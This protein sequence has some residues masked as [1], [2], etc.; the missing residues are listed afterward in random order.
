MALLAPVLGGIADRG[1]A[2]KRALFLFTS[3]GI[4]ATMALFFAEEGNWPLAA[5]LYAIAVM[6]SL[7]A[8]VFYDSLL[9]DVSDSRTVD[10][11][12]GRGY[13][14]GYLGGGLL[15]LVNVLMV[16]KPEWFGIPG[17]ADAVRL[18]FLTVAAWWA[19]FSVPLFVNIPER[20]PPG[21]PPLTA[22]IRQGLAGTGVTFRKLIHN[23]PLLLFLVAY[24]FYIDGVDTVITMAVDYGK[25]IGFGTS[26]L[27]TA[28]LMVQFVGFPFAYLLGFLGQKW[29]PKWVILVCILVYLAVT[30]LGSQ[31]DV[32]PYR[33]AGIEVNQFLVLAFLIGTVQGG[34]Q[35]LSRS[36]FTRMVPASRAGEFFGFYNMLGRFAAILGPVLLGTVARL[37]RDPRL[38]ILSVAVLFLIGGALLLRVPATVNQENGRAE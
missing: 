5:A 14:L 7:G 10:I 31:L 36:F 3:L 19:L 16:Q 28:L 33:I 30:I 18:S 4:V 25:S 27:I 6:G 35:S 20:R 29:H 17:A 34:V 12:S 15:F 37:T 21:R 1:S 11:L 2:R 22:A 13:A 32:V 23:K 38:G 24:W 8:S 9:V 26:D